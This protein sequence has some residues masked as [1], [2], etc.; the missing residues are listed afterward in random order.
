MNNTIKYS[1][2][3]VC[4]N[5]IPST[6]IF[7][8]FCGSQLHKAKKSKSEKKEVTVPEP[9][10]LPSGSWIV[11]IMIQGKI[12]CITRS[13]YSACKAEA[14]AIKSGIKKET[15]PPK[16]M[17][18]DTLLQ[19]FIEERTE[20]LSPSTIRNYESIRKNHLKSVIKQDVNSIRWQPVINEEAKEFGPKTVANVWH[21]VTGAL[22]AFDYPVPAKINLPQQ[23]RKEAEFLDYEQIQKFLEAIKGK[24]CELACLLALHSLRQSEYLAL[25]QQSIEN[26]VIHVSGAVVPNKD[27]KLVFKQTNKTV[28]SA[29]DIPV[30][31]PRLLEI[32]PKDGQTLKFQSHTT[33]HRHLHSI[34][35]KNKLPLISIHCLRHSFASLA[36]HLNWS[37]L[38]TMRIGGWS[39]PNCVQ[40]IYTHLSMMDKNDD[41]AKMKLFYCPELAEENVS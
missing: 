41:I 20:V 17:I 36:Y 2:C 24:D 40:N 6:S 21:F 28:K 9:K 5:D 37:I 30:M 11:R 39:T 3:K 26:G 12:H 25:N 18:L 8:C 4:G 33:L 31:I 7:C 16:K 32:W 35:E 15:E 13:S 1:K 38:T 19:K 29:R 14:I 23:I 27:N 10:Q 22:N 34:C